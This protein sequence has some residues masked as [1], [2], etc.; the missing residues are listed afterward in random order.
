MIF[1]WK[2][3]FDDLR[4]ELERVKATINDMP[5]NSEFGHGMNIAKLRL[6]ELESRLSLVVDHQ[7]AEAAS[8]RAEIHAAIAEMYREANQFRSL[9]SEVRVLRCQRSHA[10]YLHMRELQKQSEKGGDA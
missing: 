6:V 1:S 7:Q 2:P 8:L 3:A 4:S 9:L 5:F 10:N